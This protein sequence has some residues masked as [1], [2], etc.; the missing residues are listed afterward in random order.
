MRLLFWGSVQMI[1]GIVL[2]LAPGL[3]AVTLMVIF[4]V[5]ALMT[6]PSCW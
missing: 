3:G 4:G 2:W 5:W 6:G 1:G